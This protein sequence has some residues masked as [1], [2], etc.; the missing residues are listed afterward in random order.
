MKSFSDDL[1]RYGVKFCV[2]IISFVFIAEV[3][4]THTLGTRRVHEA[5]DL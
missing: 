4:M 5:K 3:T 2:S 1:A